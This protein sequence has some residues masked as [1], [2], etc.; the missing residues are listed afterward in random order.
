MALALAFTGCTVTTTNDQCSADSTVLC[1]QGSGYSCAGQQ[2]P[3]QTDST[4]V[5]STGTAGNAGSTLYCCATGGT[6]SGTCAPDPTV[7]NCAAGSAGYSCTGSD[8]PPQADTALSCG[9]G[10][11]GNAGSTLYCCTTAGADGGGTCSADPNPSNCTAG[12][13]TFDCTGSATPAQSNPTAICSAG[14]PGDGGLMVFCCTGVVNVADGGSE[15][16][17]DA[18]PESGGDAIADVGV[19]VDAAPDSS[20]GGV[21]SVGASS[22]SAACDQCLS[23]QCCAQLVAC[24]T[25]DEAGVDDAGNSACESI[26]SCLDACVTGNPDAGVPPE[27]LSMCETDCGNAYSPQEQQAATNLVQCQASSCAQACQ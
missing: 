4:L 18:G 10:I 9:S 17:V 21:C 15:A 22:G 1:S 8:T 6:V 11:P 2:T 24:D 5:C 26:L 27:S 19:G 20:D 7:A 16:G 13:T 25:P 3:A 14:A 23:T 12:S